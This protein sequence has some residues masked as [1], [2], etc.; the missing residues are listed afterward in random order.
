MTQQL[1]DRGVPRCVAA[2]AADCLDLAIAG[3][4]LDPDAMRFVECR[5]TE[6]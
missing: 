5:R 4:T 3:F 1:I 6:K 2:L